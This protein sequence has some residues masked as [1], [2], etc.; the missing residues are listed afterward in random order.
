MKELSDCRH[1]SDYRPRAAWRV[2]S[3]CRL[4]T[5]ATPTVHRSIILGTRTLRQP[6]LWASALALLTVVLVL[7]IGIEDHATSWRGAVIAVT[8]VAATGC[9]AVAIV[10]IARSRRPDARAARVYSRA[11]AT[12]LLTACAQCKDEDDDVNR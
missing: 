7:R 8:L 1:L 12:L 6:Q 9:L 11:A 4:W 2:S 10:A 3:A 5:I